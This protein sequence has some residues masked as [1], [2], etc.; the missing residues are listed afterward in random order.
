M[1]RDLRNI[2]IVLVLF[3]FG[4]G[5]FY[6]FLELWMQDN[7]LSVKTVS[8]IFSLCSLI[9]VLFIFLFSNYI[10]KHHLKRFVSILLFLK[11]ILLLLLFFLNHTGL[12]FFIKFFIML[13]RAIDTEITVCIYPLMS[14]VKM[15]DKT[16]GKKDIVYNFVYYIALLVSGLALGKSIGFIKFDYNTYAIISS[17]IIFIAYYVL[18]RIKLNVK[19]EEEDNK[20]EIIVYELAKNIAKDKPSNYY[21]AFLVFG[22]ISYY[23][24]TG[25]TMTFLTDVFHYDPTLASNIRVYLGI[26]AAIFAMIA[27]NFLTFKNDYINLGIKYI[28]RII[29][30]VIAIIF[31]GD[32]WFLIAFAVPRF[33][34]T[35]Y[36]HITCAP[37]INRFKGKYQLAFC[38]LREMIIYLGDF[39][40]YWLC[41]VCYK[42][43]VWHNFLWALIF[44]IITVVF[45]YIALYY[46]NKEKHDRKQLG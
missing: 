14:L 31:M 18:N 40:G 2:F 35:S 6:N 11:A 25:L 44:Q 4:E 22:Q 3:G 13:E 42:N 15:D 43:G 19:K 23:T 30:Y 12:S 5:I 17:I 34:A 45:A 41:G 33:L 32:M 8:T 38:N 20:D 16:Y 27:L 7:A 46:R 37:Y 21:L 26:A 10:R 36:S 29:F 28:T 24:I 1:K 39:I 9:A